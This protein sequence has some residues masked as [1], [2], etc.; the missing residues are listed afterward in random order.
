M[1]GPG[2]SRARDESPFES[3]AEEYDG[4][5]ELGGRIIFEIEVEAFRQVL[6]SLPR[7]WIEIGVGSGRFARALGIKTGTEPSDNLGRIAKS[8]SIRVIKGKGEDKLL[9]D[10]SFGTAFI[11][12][13]L[14]FVDNPT[15]VIER[16]AEMLEESGKMVLGLITLESPWAIHYMRKKERGHPFYSIARFYSYQEILDLVKEVGFI[17]ERTVSTLFQEPE[18]V[19]HVEPPRDGFF[20]ESGFVVVVS[21]KSYE[22]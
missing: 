10:G 14:C 18:R 6:P 9:P 1:N 2:S 17:H 22:R 5:F 7:P 15:L 21:R 8:R 12:V 4:W 3:L 20:P 13:T 16:T 11:I 19:D